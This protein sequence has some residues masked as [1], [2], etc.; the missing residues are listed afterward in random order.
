V[1]PT[2]ERLLRATEELL[3]EQG[4]AR[5]SLRDITE[6][7]GANVAAV[8]YHFRSKDALVEE[9]FR[10]ALEEVTEQR[11]RQLATLAPDADLR[12]VVRTWLAPALDPSA[13]DPRE[14]QLWAL[15]ARGMREEAPGLAAAVGRVSA[16]IDDEL[17]ALL[18]SHLSHLGAEEVRVRHT[19]TLAALSSL[20]VAASAGGPAPPDADLLLDWVV[21]G[22][23][24]PGRSAR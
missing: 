11:R 21:A 2:A 10:R 13:Q 16:G 8:S 18:S 24:G 19:A 6:R 3:H 7:A 20:T 5:I 12:D 4:Q 23:S 22:L 14:A 17:A 1:H 15:I 9:T